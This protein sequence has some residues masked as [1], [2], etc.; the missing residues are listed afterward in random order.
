LLPFFSSSDIPPEMTAQVQV[1]KTQQGSLAE[2]LPG[3]LRAL[4]AGGITTGGSNADRTITITRNTRVRRLSVISAPG[5]D[6][7][8]GSP[9][10]IHVSVSLFAHFLLRPY[11]LPE[12][13]VLV[14]SSSSCLLR[15]WDPT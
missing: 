15:C 13:S 9:C 5:G 7:K 11:L 4:N 6:N 1:L 10:P 3:I 12:I 2:E 8:D 14:D